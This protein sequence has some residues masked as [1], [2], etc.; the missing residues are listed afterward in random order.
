L[1]KINVPYCT[2][3]LF[4]DYI[5]INKKPITLK[6]N[7]MSKS[8]IFKAAHKMAKSFEGH[9]SACFALALREIYASM[10]EEKA[11]C[12]ISGLPFDAKSKRQK[13]HPEVSLLMS[14]INRDREYNYRIVKNAVIAKKGAFSSIEELKGFIK[15]YKEVF[16]LNNISAPCSEINDIYM[17]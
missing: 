11:V 10:K 14:N 16:N 9:Y 1:I 17:Y 5:C 6:T 2:L 7:D 12:A 8:E 13:N 15:G 4:L 3:Y